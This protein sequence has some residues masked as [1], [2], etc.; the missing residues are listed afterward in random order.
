[1]ATCIATGQGEPTRAAF[2]QALD[3]AERLAA[4][5]PDRADYQRDL[6][7]SLLRTSAERTED[8]M[9]AFVILSSLAASG[10]LDPVDQPVLDELERALRPAS[11]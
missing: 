9:R 11:S 1:M 2:Q 7:T 4:A 3:I 5:E 10:R 6:A 8:L